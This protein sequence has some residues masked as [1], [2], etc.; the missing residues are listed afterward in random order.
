[1]LD[2]GSNGGVADVG[3][4]GLVLH[5]RYQ[6]GHDG[7]VFAGCRSRARAADSSPAAVDIMILPTASRPIGGAET[8]EIT[9]ELVA[10]RARARVGR[11]G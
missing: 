7:A 10:R 4:S 1:M 5:S 6:V 9:F 8:V 11:S 2:V 3:E